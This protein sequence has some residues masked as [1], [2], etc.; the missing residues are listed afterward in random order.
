MPP[1]RRLA[2]AL[3]LA[4]LRRTARP[5]PHPPHPAAPCPAAGIK[6]HILR[7]GPDASEEAN[8]V[9]AWLEVSLLDA[10]KSGYAKKFV[11][12]VCRDAEATR[13]L[14]EVSPRLAPAC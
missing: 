5:L 9:M 13:P 10:V 7:T 12:G 1:R 11:F 3:P 2:P 4:A 14:E 8:S 6:P